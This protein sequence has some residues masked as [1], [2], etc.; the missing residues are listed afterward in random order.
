MT[1]GYSEARHRSLMRLWWRASVW[2]LMAGAGGGLLALGLVQLLAQHVFSGEADVLLLHLALAVN[3]DV[4]RNALYLELLHEGGP[5][6][7]AH[8]EVVTVDVGHHLAPCSL[9]RCGAGHIS[10]SA[11][12][13]QLILQRLYGFHGHAAGAAPGGPEIHE[14]GLALVLGHYLAEDVGAR[15]CITQLDDVCS[16]LTCLAVAV[17]AVVCALTPWVQNA[18][19]AMASSTSRIR[20]VFMLSFLIVL[21]YIIYIYARERSPSSVWQQSPYPSRLQSYG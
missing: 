16:C 7:L 2:C 12:A 18:P 4:G 21:L 8:I 1:D 3:H 13:P 5:L 10:E 15:E 6:L 20:L 19:L 11:L 14:H 9:R 17:L